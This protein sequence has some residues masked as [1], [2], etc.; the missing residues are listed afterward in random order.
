[1]NK[2]AYFLHD[3][4]VA[5]SDAVV[6]VGHK[7]SLF[8]MLNNASFTLNLFVR[9]YYL[10]QNKSADDTVALMSDIRDCIDDMIKSIPDKLAQLPTNVVD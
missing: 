8:D 5:M 7:L 6:A 4:L 10:T 3:K 9:D 2:D 1:M